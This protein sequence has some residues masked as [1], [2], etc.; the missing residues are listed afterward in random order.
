MTV[1]LDSW[2]VLCLLQGE[3][4]GAMRVEQ[5]LADRPV[6]SWINLGEVLY[7]LLRRRTREEAETAVRDVAAVAHVEL[8]S[9]ALV[10]RA[11]ELKAAHAMAYADAFAAATALTHDG[12]LWTGD[13]ELLIADAPWKV[14]DLRTGWLK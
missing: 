5:V 13:P 8:P 14:T 10:R 3:E 4:P 12:Q 7:V 11:V 9:E 6:M 1:V 2:A